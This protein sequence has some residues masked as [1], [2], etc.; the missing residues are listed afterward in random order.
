MEN[1]S[2]PSPEVLKFHH[3]QFT[4]TRGVS[5]MA[6]RTMKMA[7][8][9][10]AMALWAAGPAAAQQRSVHVEE[11]GNGRERLRI[12]ATGDI[13]F[14]DDDRA[15][16]AVAP[17]G[18]LEIEQSHAGAPLRRVVWT[19]DGGGVR[20]AYFENDRAT[21]PD[22][23]A[24]EWIGKMV[25]DAVRESGVGAERRVARIRARRG[26][27][28]VLDEITRIRSDGAKRIYYA[29]LLKTPSL[30]AGETARA[31]RHAGEHISSDGEKR[32][33]LRTV[34]DRPSVSPAELAALYDAAA[35]IG[36]DG[37]KALLLRDAS[38]RRGLPDARAADAF[39]RAAQTIASDGEKAL[40]LRQVARDGGVRDGFFRVADS[41]GSDGEH[42]LVLSTVLRLDGVRPG[43]AAA[44]LRSAARIGS[45]GEK[46]Q[47]LRATPAA[48]LRDPGVREAYR[49]ALRTI[50]SSGERE[51]AERHLERSTR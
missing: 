15:V 50:G 49:A 47:V 36:S 5:T 10:A 23:E 7:A 51:V 38:R 44:A 1:G 25:S 9:L 18:R 6:G 2:G 29:A 30:S 11:R 17:G 19:H 42:A 34:L 3:L 8:A 39:F 41:V 26:T 16:A 46:A 43:V 12:E 32:L 4:F 14:S 21:R 13:D 37:E 28:G 35:R 31:L 48:L 22:A 33:A 40:V 45:D 24:R 20:E 27:E